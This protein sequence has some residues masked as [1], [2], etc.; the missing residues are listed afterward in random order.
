MEKGGWK[1]LLFIV[2][3]TYTDT[4]LIKSLEYLLCNE[5]LYEVSNTRQRNNSQPYLQSMHWVTYL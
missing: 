4:A 2:T 3:K 1:M 5:L